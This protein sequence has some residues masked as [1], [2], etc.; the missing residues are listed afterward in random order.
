MYE[1][2]TKQVLGELIKESAN[3]YSILLVSGFVIASLI[4]RP[5]KVWPMA[6]NFGPSIAL[7]NQKFKVKVT[8]RGGVLEDVLGPEDVFEDTF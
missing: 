6:N 2:K 4:P 8:I 7:K 1:N 5:R 3:I